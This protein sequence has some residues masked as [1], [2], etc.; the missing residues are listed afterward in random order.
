[1]SS[2]NYH[3]SAADAFCAFLPQFSSEVLDH[4]VVWNSDFEFTCAMT[5]NALTG[6]LN[7]CKLRL[8]V[9][10]EVRGG[11]S[12]LKLGFVDFD[13][14][15]CAGAGHTSFKRLLLEPYPG[16]ERRP[17]NSAVKLAVEIRHLQGDPLFKRPP[18]SVPPDEIG[19]FGQ[20]ILPEPP[21]VRTISA[22]FAAIVEESFVV[23]G[24]VGLDLLI[25]P[26]GSVQ[27][28]TRLRAHTE[29]PMS[30]KFSTFESFSVPND[31]CIR[32]DFEQLTLLS[33]YQTE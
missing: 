13:L 18:Y 30:E 1:M 26:D 29:P 22:E 15:E 31:T 17:D 6:V 28:G 32:T 24:Q 4:H 5:A 11:K 8:S 25:D 3:H 19:G 10:K 20:Y 2:F 21:P 12:A 33:K 16:S 7:S 14:A 9:R 27:L 23:K